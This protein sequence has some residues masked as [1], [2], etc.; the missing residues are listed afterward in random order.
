M[1]ETRG[2]GPAQ[3]I[4]QAHVTVDNRSLGEGNPQIL[5][6]RTAHCDSWVSARSHGNTWKTD[7]LGNY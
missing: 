3:G 4:L 7:I 1:M 5:S 2:S 6:F